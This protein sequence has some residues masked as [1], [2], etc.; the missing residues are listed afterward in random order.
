MKKLLTLCLIAALTTLC[1]LNLTAADN[2]STPAEK[3]EKKGPKHLPF[4]GKL[5]AIDVSA[6]TL[7][8][9]ERTFHVTSATKIMK[10]G[11]PARLDDATVGEEVGGAYH[12]G[13]ND[14]LERMSLRIGPKPAKEGNKEDKK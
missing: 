5:D 7:K 1:N 11:K 9:G 10:A 12:E 4:H 3:G 8:V 13:E 14:K 6:K 2:K